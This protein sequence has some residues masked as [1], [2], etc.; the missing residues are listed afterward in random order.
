MPEY[1]TEEL[2]FERAVASK[3][4]ARVVKTLVEQPVV[5]GDDE[6]ESET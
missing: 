6:E 5:E 2:S 4:Y 1:L 3:F